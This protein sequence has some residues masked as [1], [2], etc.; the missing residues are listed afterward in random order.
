MKNSVP[1]SDLVPGGWTPSEAGQ[2][3]Y[4]K[5]DAEDPSVVIGSMPFAERI[6]LLK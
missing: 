6:K 4:L 1:Q 2:T 5:I 3:R